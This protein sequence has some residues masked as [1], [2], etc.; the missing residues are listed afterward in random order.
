MRHTRT[1]KAL[2]LITQTYFHMSLTSQQQLLIFVIA[3]RV[4]IPF[5]RTCVLCDF[6]LSFVVA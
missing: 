6:L 2:T 4:S 3:F 1:V 5:S